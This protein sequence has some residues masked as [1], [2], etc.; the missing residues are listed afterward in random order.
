MKCPAED[1]LLQ[2]GDCIFEGQEW[3]EIKEHISICAFC[4]NKLAEFHQED[5]ILKET[6]QTPT[7]P[8]NFTAVIIDQLEPY[9]SVSVL[10]V[11]KS[12]PWKRILA[13][14]AGLTITIGIST[15]FNPALAGWIGGLFSSERVDVGLQMA[16]R[17]GFVT[18]VNK[19]VS[20]NGL[21]F[22]VEDV[23]ADS[24]R[25][26]FSYQVLDENGKLKKPYI[27]LQDPTNHIIAT[28]LNGNK[29]DLSSMSWGNQ[30]EYGQ[31]E[32][33]FHGNP[34]AEQLHVQFN[35]TKIAGKEGNWKLEVPVDLRQSLKATQIVS[36]AGVTSKQH[37]VIINMKEIRFSPSA[38]E[39]IYE[40]S[41]TKEELDRYK[42]EI[43]ELE[44]R[45]GEH[46][47]AQYGNKIQY[48]IENEAGKT[49]SQHHTFIEGKGHPSDSGGLFASGQYLDELGQTAWVDTFIPQ[50]TKNKLTFVLDGIFKTEPT[51]FAVTFKPGELKKEPVT[52]EYEGNVVKLKEAKIEHDFSLQKSI[53]PIKKERVLIIEMEGGKDVPSS[54][55]GYWVL[56]D[57][58]GKPY[59]TV[60][61]GSILDE[62]DENGRYKT[63]TTL[64]SLDFTGELPEELTLQL[65]SVER[66]YEIKDKWKVPLY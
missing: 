41:F 33:N 28:D 4:Q 53:N 45:F 22:K 40:T 58:K 31:F 7:L 55:L 66:Y 36:L 60:H 5:L 39:L 35:L 63:K 26:A 64:Q 6:L 15:A 19:E 46:S 47:L 34:V 59:S 3:A 17:E 14:A 50:K 54:D 62:K 1:K 49:I 43:Q 10:K 42:T 16:S 13:A 56:V 18:H 20:D 27:D 61:S 51:D 65:L 32:F 21:I 25:I 11:K 38:S 24:S 52:F 37:G 44:Q 29:I 23:I 8:E 12:T 30:D 48:H 2:F 57:S 9:E